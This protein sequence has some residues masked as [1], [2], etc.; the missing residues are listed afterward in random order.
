[1]LEQSAFSQG[2]MMSCVP[3]AAAAAE[4]KLLSLRN[5][6]NYINERRTGRL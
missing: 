4:F 1:M 6:G 2:G 3:F 5:G